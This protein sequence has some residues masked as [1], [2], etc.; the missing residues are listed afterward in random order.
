MEPTDWLTQ[1]RLP[2]AFALAFAIAA[3]D[4]ATGMASAVG[5]RLLP[6]R[7]AAL[8]AAIAATIPVLLL[9]G[10]TASDILARCLPDLEALAITPQQVA[11]AAAATALVVLGATLCGRVVPSL[12]L[13]ATAMAVCHLVE[14]GAPA[15]VLALLP[16][17]IATAGLP[18]AAAVLALLVV[19][20]TV[21]P[22]HRGQRPR[23]RLRRVFPILAGLTCGISVWLVLEAAADAYGGA[24]LPDWLVPGLALVAF[25]AGFAMV[26]LWLARRPFWI[27]D[28]VDG[29]EA[30][31]RRLTMAGSLGLAFAAG[32]QQA[33]LAVSVLAVGLPADQPVLD[34]M[35]G[36]PLVLIVAAIGLFLGLALLGHRPASRHGG[37]VSDSPALGAGANLAAGAALAAGGAAGLPLLGGPAAAGALAG[38]AMAADR[39]SGIGALL[40]IWL[41]ATLAAAG[42]AVAALHLGRA[43]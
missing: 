16:V 18:L 30:G 29:I 25:L 33:V 10:P 26:T 24:S 32:G 22:M 7:I 40:V 20:R 23:D 36:W 42:L 13:L 31:H 12:F 38:S 41:V 11:A 3:N 34:P 39:R 1:A 15:S 27:A 17:L 37:A 6:V 21:T 14:G 35:G 8:L 5:G 43:M 19:R 28:R 2:L 9:A 4:A